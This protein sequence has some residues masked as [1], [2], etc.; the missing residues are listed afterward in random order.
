[1]SIEEFH[2]DFDSVEKVAKNSGEKSYFE[3]VSQNEVLTFISAC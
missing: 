2:V 3:K 1:M